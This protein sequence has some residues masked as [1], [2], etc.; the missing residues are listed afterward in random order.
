MIPK[1]LSIKSPLMQGHPI[2]LPELVVERQSRD[3][4]AAFHLYAGPGV[5]RLVAGHALAEPELHLRPRPI[6]TKLRPAWIHHSRSGKREHPSF[7]AVEA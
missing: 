5:Q 3:E 6:G 4:A 1:K 7:S 2:D